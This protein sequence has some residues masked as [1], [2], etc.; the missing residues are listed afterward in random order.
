MES[1]WEQ[2]PASGEQSDLLADHRQQNS[3]TNTNSDKEGETLVI[4]I[5]PTG[6]K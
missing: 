3:T 2:R 5:V 6:K 1:V 4:S